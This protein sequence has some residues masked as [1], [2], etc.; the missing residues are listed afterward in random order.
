MLQVEVL[1]QSKMDKTAV[2][3]VVYNLEQNTLARIKREIEA[4]K[5]TTPPSHRHDDSSSRLGMTT[6]LWL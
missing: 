4:A 2:Q 6:M 5:V 1:T 3:H